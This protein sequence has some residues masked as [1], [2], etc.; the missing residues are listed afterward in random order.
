MR[1]AAPAA[2]PPCACRAAFTT[3]H[4][5]PASHSRVLQIRRA[6][7]KFH[8][9]P[10]EKRRYEPF[11]RA[12][13]ADHRYD[14]R[15]KGQKIHVGHIKAT[16]VGATAL[17]GVRAGA[18]LFCTLS[19]PVTNDRDGADSNTAAH[20]GRQGTAGKVEDR[21]TVR[22]IRADDVTPFGIEFQTSRN[23]GR[24]K[25]QVAA[26]RPLSPAT[27]AGLKAGDTILRIGQRWVYSPKQAI[28]LLQLVHLS[29]KVF[30]SRESSAQR[31]AGP[32]SDTGHDDAPAA[33]AGLFHRTL[34]VDP[35]GI[36]SASSAYWNESAMVTTGQ[37]HTV[38]LLKVFDRKPHKKGIK[39]GKENLLI[40]VAKVPLQDV[41]LYCMTTGNA[42]STKLAL[43][44]SELPSSGMVGRIELS[45]AHSA[46]P[47]SAVEMSSGRRTES[48]TGA[49]SVTTSDGGAEQ[50]A[51]PTNRAELDA[52]M[53]TVQT[54]IDLEA[55]T[56]SELER[57]LDEAGPDHRPRL[58]ANIKYSDERMHDLAARMIRVVSALREQHDAD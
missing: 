46:M 18:K 19:L 41:A 16:V 12:P 25:C 31:T 22:L 56:R 32:S 50:Q 39:L 35:T 42:Y 45:V 28:R 43:Q 58:N 36:E 6:I 34:P 40:G 11:F 13:A 2:L 7:T 49:Q 38:L 9:F 30:V 21:L 23:P 44:A 53:S 52:M 8:T 24:A 33:A 3:L 54:Q 47:G 15:A 29:V 51:L 37:E 26:I 55:E 4:H 20:D 10:A 27:G 17:L 5:Y 14:L 48:F 1:P 57:Q